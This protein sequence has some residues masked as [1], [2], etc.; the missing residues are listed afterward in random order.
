MHILVTNDTLVRAPP[1]D[2]EILMSSIP[3]VEKLG[4]CVLSG[5]AIHLCVIGMLILSL[6]GSCKILRKL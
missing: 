2:L 4:E 6:V 5:K 3:K 1:R